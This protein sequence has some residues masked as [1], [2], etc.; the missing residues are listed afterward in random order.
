MG[1]A[2]KEE[3]ELLIETQ[4]RKYIN[5]DG[6]LYLRPPYHQRLVHQYISNDGNLY[7]RPPYHQRLSAPPNVIRANQNAEEDPVYRWRVCSN[8]RAV[9][10]HPSAVCCWKSYCSKCDLEGSHTDKKC[11]RFPPQPYNSVVDVSYLEAINQM[12]PPLV[13]LLLDKNYGDQIA[14]TM[15][16][17][18]INRASKSNTDEEI[19]VI[20]EQMNKASLEGLRCAKTGVKNECAAVSKKKP[21]GAKGWSA[22]VKKKSVKKSVKEKSVKEGKSVE[23]ISVEDKSVE[24]T[25]V[26]EKSGK[27]ELVRILEIFETRE[28]LDKRIAEEEIIEEVVEQIVSRI[29]EEEALEKTNVLEDGKNGMSNPCANLGAVGTW[30]L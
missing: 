14:N 6:N 30:V 13:S 16:R 19:A 5:K 9:D 20:I 29:V 26:E 12:R 27:E 24:D 21:A 7:F 8:C 4:V 22:G 2:R 15:R 17:L 28:I 11:R 23:K 10:S 3:L 18:A 25:S 1:K